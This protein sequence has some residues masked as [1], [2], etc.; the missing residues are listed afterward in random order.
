LD[1]RWLITIFHEHSRFVTA[2]QIFMEESTENVTWL[3]NKAIHEYTKPPEILTD[4]G[5]QFWSVRRG[6]SNFDTY[7]QQQKVGHILN[8]IGKPTT[9]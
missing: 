9:L 6:E 5:S 1:A 7:R 8:G 2:S 4:H 3:L